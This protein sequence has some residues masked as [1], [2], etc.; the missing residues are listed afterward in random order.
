LGSAYPRVFGGILDV[1]GELV[2][3]NGSVQ[4]TILVGFHGSTKAYE[5]AA[6]V[7]QLK[8]GAPYSSTIGVFGVGSNDAAFAAG[9]RTLVAAARSAGMAVHF[10]LSPGT[11][12]D[13]H[14]VQFVVRKGLPLF[15]SSWGL[16]K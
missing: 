5:S 16:A 14:T 10:I 12:H 6:P 3:A 13:W 2:P 1:S 8:R 7:N 11:A 9:A 4:H 15:Y